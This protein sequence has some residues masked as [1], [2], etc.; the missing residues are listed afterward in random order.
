M[1]S[2]AV[3]LVFAILFFVLFFPP[4]VAEAESIDDYQDMR[5]GFIGSKV[6]VIEYASFTCPHCATFHLDVF[7][8]LDKEYIETRKVNFIYREVYFDAPGLWAG[9]LA[10]CVKPESYFG[11]VELLYKRQ[12]SWTKS[13]SEQEILSGLFTIGRQLGLKE[14]K[15][16]ACMKNKK[17]ALN[18]VRA[19]QENAK[20]DGISSTPSLII[21]GK[22][23]N[24][25]SYADLKTEL[26]RLLD[27]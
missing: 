3:R 5:K 24:N 25:L 6:T 18:L 16:M 14:S 10:R 22:L 27:L 21:N 7:P 9:L 4:V 17:K 13:S 2:L 11:V 23:F 12:S 26:D 19:Y 20:I 1:L 8:K 15:I